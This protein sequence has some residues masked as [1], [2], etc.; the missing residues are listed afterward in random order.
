MEPLRTL[1]AVAVP[2]AEN[3]IDT[4]Q[5]CPARFVRIPYGPDYRNIFLH[6]RR[7]DENGAM[8]A[9]FVLNDPVY[10]DAQIIVAGHGFG[11]GSSREG[12]VAAV[13]AYGLRCV[14]AGSFG[15]IFF[16]NCGRRGILAIRLPDAPLQEL[17]AFL[18]S[19]RGAS[20]RVDLAQ[21]TI[22]WDGGGTSFDVGQLQKRCLMEGVSALELARRHLHQIEAF[23]ADVAKRLPWATSLRLPL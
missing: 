12:A 5:L 16:D 17:H 19:A 8:R 21:Q 18:R 6:D 22:G 13:Q 4:D 11:I 20:L 3:G 23:E 2:L 9:D 10:S 7:F 15:D 14:V 1:E